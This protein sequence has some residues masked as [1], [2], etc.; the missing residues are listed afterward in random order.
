MGRPPV[1]TGGL[2]ASQLSHSGVVLC[3]IPF[4]QPDFEHYLFV[5][6]ALT[7]FRQSRVPYHSFKTAGK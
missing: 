4:E 6:E 5:K 1:G 3:P 2:I 7:D